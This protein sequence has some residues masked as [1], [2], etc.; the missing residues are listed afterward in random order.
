VDLLGIDSDRLYPAKADNNA[1]FV[2]S[3]FSLLSG[4]KDYRI[5]RNYEL[6]DWDRLT[7][8]LSSSAERRVTQ[9]PNRN[10]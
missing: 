6:V 9:V 4:E 10:L 7:D 5:D 8:S 3:Y 2:G 1:V